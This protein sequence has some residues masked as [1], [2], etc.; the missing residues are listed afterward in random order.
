MVYKNMNRQKEYCENLY[1]E[2]KEL[3]PKTC[4][5]T[6]DHIPG[7]TFDNIPCIKPEDLTRRKDVAKEIRE[8]CKESLGLKPEKWA[9]IE[10]DK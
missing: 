3:R 9:E 5:K 6:M 4:M 8:K 10:G 2:Y 1:K 7:K